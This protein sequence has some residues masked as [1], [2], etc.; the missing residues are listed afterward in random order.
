MSSRQNKDAKQIVAD[1]I[2]KIMLSTPAPKRH[3][4]HKKKPT[5]K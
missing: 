4:S 5:K 3:E 2:L 1:E